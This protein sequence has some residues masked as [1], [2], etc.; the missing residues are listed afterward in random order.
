[1]DFRDLNRTSPKD[2][3]CVSYIDV[4]VDNVA[5]NSIYSF[6]DDFSRYKPNKNNSRR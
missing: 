4:L 6:M 2:N 1:M 3:F 5:F